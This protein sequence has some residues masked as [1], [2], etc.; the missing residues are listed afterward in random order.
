[1]FAIICSGHKQ[2]KVSSGDLIRVPYLAGENPKTTLQLKPLALEEGSRFLM[3]SE[4]LK[5][6]TVTAKIL[7]HGLGKKTI[8][9][10]KK[11][12][13]GY[14]K[15]QGHR[16]AFTELRIIEIK[17]PSGKILSQERIKTASSKKKTS[18][19]VKASETKKLKTAEKAL[20]K[21]KKKIASA[22]SGSPVEKTPQPE[23][24]RKAASTGNKPMDQKKREG[25]KT[26]ETSLKTKKT[27][28]KSASQ[29][30]VQPAVKSKNSPQKS[31]GK[32]T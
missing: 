27:A 15:T 29:T 28:G 32:K 2:F 11:R 20:E 4:D 24:T 6:A 25:K 23:K 9:F 18:T 26:S 17:L 7:R 31:S 22:G 16:Q 10:K 1:M 8:V 13:K 19:D 21:N 12:R 30:K 5:K 3:G 14:R